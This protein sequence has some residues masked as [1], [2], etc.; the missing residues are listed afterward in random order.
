MEREVCVVLGLIKN[1]PAKKVDE[2]WPWAC[3]SSWRCG[4]GC[5]VV[6][7]DVGL[8]VDDDS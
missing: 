4:C 3:C 5:G 2:P 7:D 1:E 8:A 6:V